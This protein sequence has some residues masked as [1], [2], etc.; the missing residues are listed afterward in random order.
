MSGLLFTALELSLITSLTVLAL[1]LSYKMLNI[2]DLSTD[3]C[4]TLGASVGAVVAVSGHPYLSIPLAMLAGMCSGLIVALLQ[5]VCGI[6]SLLAGI[7]VNTGLYSINILVMGNSSLVNL[8][9]VETI[10]TQLKELLIDTPLQG[11][12]TIIIVGIFVILTII[13][14]VFFLSTKL[15]LAI[16]ATGDNS[17][18]VNASSINP[19]FTIIIGLCLSNSFTALSGCLLAQSQKSTNI[20]I[21]SGMLTISLASLLIGYVFFN[22]K[23]IPIKTIGCVAGAFIF[24]VIYTIALRLNMPSYMLKLISAIIVA[25]SLAIPYI[26]QQLPIIKRRRLIAKEMK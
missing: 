3:G 18:M 10:F 22:K 2:C 26:K 23:S 9:K 14:L 12:Q 7:V 25:V 17:D 19:T 5:T 11:K 6:N 8:N 16:R 20:D 1:F 24:R 15:G 21:G 13:F 4:F